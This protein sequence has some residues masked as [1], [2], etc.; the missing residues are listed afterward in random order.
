MPALY[1]RSKTAHVIVD[2]SNVRTA[3]PNVDPLNRKIGH[4]A[5]IN[6]DMPAVLQADRNTDVV[7]EA[8][9]NGNVLPVLQLNGHARE[10]RERFIFD[11]LLANA[12]A[13][14]DQYQ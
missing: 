7:E 1:I 11:Q 4:H 6:R 14:K 12:R 5:R 8:A 9:A 3:I 10:M 13:G 2:D